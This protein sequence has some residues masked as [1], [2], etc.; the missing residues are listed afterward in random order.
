MWFLIFW[1]PR[2]QK[3]EVRLCRGAI[4]D[5]QEQVECVFGPIEILE[6]LALGDDGGDDN[7]GLL[8]GTLHSLMQ[9]ND[10]TDRAVEKLFE[11]LVKKAYIAGEKRG[12]ESAKTAQTEPAPAPQIDANGRLVLDL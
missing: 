1:C 6:T 2:T 12:L 3:I 7:Y 9:L 8:F 11:T 5:A 10:I 4:D